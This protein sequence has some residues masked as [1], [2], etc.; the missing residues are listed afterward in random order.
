MTLASDISVTGEVAIEPIEQGF[1]IAVKLTVALKAIPKKQVEVLVAT[2]HQVCSYSN[3][4]GGDIA[5]D[6]SLA[7]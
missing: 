1:A 4:T 5:V 3:A 6:I 2:D 7:S